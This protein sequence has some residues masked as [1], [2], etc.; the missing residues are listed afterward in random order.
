MLH[1]GGDEAVAYRKMSRCGP[2]GQQ[3]VQGIIHSLQEASF[4]RI[5]P[6]MMHVH[7]I[8]GA[9]RKKGLWESALLVLHHLEVACA[10]DEISYGMVMKAC[11][12][13]AHWKSVLQLLCEYP[14]CHLGILV[15]VPSLV[16]GHG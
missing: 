6:N 5:S 15:L 8:L 1:A 9:C 10:M 14:A 7:S 12:V 2:V 16:D 13:A 4:Q 3:G 11:A